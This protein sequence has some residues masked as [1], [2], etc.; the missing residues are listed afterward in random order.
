MQQLH[1]LGHHQW[2]KLR[3]KALGKVGIG[4]Q[5]RPM[6]AAIGVVL[7]LPQMHQLIDH[8]GIALEIT[9]EVLVVPTLLDRRIT[10]LLI[11]PDCLRHLA[12]VQC[13]SPEFI[14]CHDACPPRS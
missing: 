7:E 5:R 12:N 8:A 6:G 11:Q 13:V 4:E 3:G 10:E 14:E 9:D 1:L 2:T